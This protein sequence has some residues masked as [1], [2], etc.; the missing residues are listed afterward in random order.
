MKA[1]LL[2]LCITLFVYACGNSEN[3]TDTSTTTT[4][5]PEADSAPAGGADDLSGN[6]DY[7]KGLELIAKSD[8]LTCHKIEDR[9]TGPAYREVANKYTADEKTIAMLA[10]KIIKGGSGV[11]GTVP[12]TPHPTLSEPD[13]QQM[14]KYIML[15][16]QK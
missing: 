13:A 9:L 11:W 12:M 15:L 2:L 6:P 4:T 8:C 5:T 7:Q 10:T 1:Y 14:V 16:K 3:K